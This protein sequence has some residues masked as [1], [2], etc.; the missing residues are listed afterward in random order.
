MIKL[1]LE[2]RNNFLF[3]KIKVNE[4]K[5][6]QELFYTEE[7]YVRL[8]KD[9]E[10]LEEKCSSAEILKEKMK[11]EV[12]LKRN[13]VEKM[14]EES[15]DIKERLQK[16]EQEFINEKENLLRSQEVER[17]DWN[18]NKEE[19]LRRMN[20]LEKLFQS[21]CQENVKLK[22]DYAK[23]IQILQKDVAQTVFATF[24]NNNFI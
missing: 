5:A 8:K 15:E 17:N 2:R 14:N 19:K 10:I 22:G 20:E 1:N 21:R 24:A 12:K 7:E 11:N 4:E 13:Q 18:R 23:L 9:L 3:E 16:K 6:P